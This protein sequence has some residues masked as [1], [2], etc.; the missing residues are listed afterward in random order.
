MAFH[1]PFRSAVLTALVASSVLALPCVQA[2][3]LTALVEAASGYDAQWRAALAEREAAARRSDQARAPLLPQLGVGAELSR[4]QTRSHTDLA[5]A[6]HTG[7]TRSI[8]IEASQAL[9]RPT[10][11]LQYAQSQRAIAL[12]QHQLDAA[13]QALIVR[14]AQAYF[15]VL[16][17]E[18]TLTFVKA[19]KAAVQEQLAAAQRNFEVGNATITDTREAQA[20]FDLI[21]AQEIAAANDLEIKKLALDQTVGIVQA[22]PWRL[23]ENAELPPLTPSSVLDWTAAAERD[24][25]QIQRALVALDIARM[26]TEKARTGHLPTVDLTA[27]LGQTSNPDGTP[28]NALGARNRQASIGVQLN[29]PLFTGFA[30][31]NRVRE[32]VALEEQA[33]AQLDDVRR[34]VLQ[35]TRTAFLGLQSRLSQVQALEAAQA[36]SLSAL[37]ANQLG[38]EVG[39]RINLDVL[40]AQSQLFDTRR[41]LAQARY[42]VLLT[43]LQLA[44]ASGT[45]DMEDV[46]RINALLEPR[47]G[48]AA[49]TAVAGDQ[50]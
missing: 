34:Q 22:R 13:A 19:Q 45:L 33:R 24:Q 47:S 23:R 15:E 43:H 6:R 49:A 44:Q 5:D 11:R 9:Y 46:R 25:P 39:V 31:E 10:D 21:H 48:D 1:L 7:T 3:S 14:V 17:A 42:D 26:E 8:A 16:A 4:A 37:E 28:S 12:A 20:R 32:T 40:D 36:S 35:A 38:Y 18:D 29:L 50:R 30:V 2:Q 41:Q 27:R